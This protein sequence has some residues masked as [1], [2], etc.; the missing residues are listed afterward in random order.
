MV[1]ETAYPWTLNWN[2]NTHN[3]VG[4]EQLL[5]EYPASVNGQKQF[6]GDLLNIVENIPNDLGKGFCYWSPC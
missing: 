3:I 2:D 5:D 6:L 4:S 1:V